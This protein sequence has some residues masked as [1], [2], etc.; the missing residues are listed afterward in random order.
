MDFKSVIKIRFLLRPLHLVYRHFV[1]ILL[2]NLLLV[3]MPQAKA[4]GNNSLTLP[5]LAV[6]PPQI[7][8]N[9][10]QWSETFNKALY[11]G[12]SQSGAYRVFSPE[13]LDSRLHRK[14]DRMPPSCF[15]DDCIK[16]VGRKLEVDY[17]IGTKIDMQEGDY[18]FT[19]V[20]YDVNIR[21]KV[22]AIK[23]NQSAEPDKIL[24]YCRNAVNQL[25]R[26][27]GGKIV[28]DLNAKPN[29]D[30]R[31]L[32]T[33]LSSGL[34]LGIAAS[35]Y[36]QGQLLFEDDN[37]HVL[38]RSP[39]SETDA[40][41]SDLRGFFAS[42]AP[43]AK[44]S[45]LG[46]AGVADVNNGPSILMNPAGLASLQNQSFAFSHRNLPGDIPSFYSSYASPLYWGITQ[47]I[48][49]QFEGD[50][51]ARETVFHF[52]LATD[53]ARL[54][55]FISRLYG[56]LAVKAY[57]LQ[58]G[59][60]GQ[61]VDRSTGHSIGVG[62]DLGL[63]WPLSDKLQAGIHLRDVSSYIRHQNT[64]RDET[65]REILPPEMTIGGVYQAASSLWFYLDGQ[66]GLFAD[67]S[68]HVRMGIDKGFLGLIHTRMGMNQILGSETSRLLTFGLGL[69]GEREGK[70]LKAN[71]A[72]HFGIED[73]QA[74][75]YRQ[76]FS[77]ELGL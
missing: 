55:P 10:L 44:Y 57:M 62:L 32:W 54:S 66:K 76:Q 37:R 12:A 8:S 2:L 45:G 73:S 5:T 17:A 64:L 25:Q 7:E 70:A 16:R 13:E 30:H 60:E 75:E 49:V 67:Q 52:A 20:L 41:I 39:L 72:V 59:K 46:G 18:V 42:S 58:I 53:L 65:Y 24:I 47:G 43:A 9:L 27:P 19:L 23:I 68:D 28:A 21:G 15:T 11:M 36:F 56:G 74:L 51:L 48:A 26:E 3:W 71:Y 1:H 69:E 63:Q 31:L 6:L 38:S 35:A 14:Q 22:K 34:L 33:S 61:G 40:N 50:G 4:A 77:L 29:Q